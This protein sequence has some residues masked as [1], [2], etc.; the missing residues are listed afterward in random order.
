MVVMEGG[1]G[2][3][4]P[5]VLLYYLAFFRRGGVEKTHAYIGSPQQHW[6]LYF[7]YYLLF[8]FLRRSCTISLSA[9]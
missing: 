7:I 1:K 3:F 5:Y 8:L 6:H 2:G 4:A 9:R